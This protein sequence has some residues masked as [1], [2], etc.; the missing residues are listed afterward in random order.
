MTKK[1]Y[2]RALTRATLVLLSLPIVAQSQPPG[3]A[4]A[5]LPAGDAKAFVEGVCTACHQTNLIIGSAGY[6]QAHWRSL[7]DT[8]IKL[9]EV[10]A[11]SVTQYLATNFPATTSRQPELVPGDTRIRFQ[12]WIVPTLGQRPRDPLQMEDGTIWWTGQY[13]SLIGRLNPATGEMKEF[14]LAPDA[15]PHSIIADAEGNIWY[16][17][18]GNGTVGM[19]EPTSGKI[20]VYPMPD[21]AARDP[22]TPIFDEDGRLWFTLQLSSMIGR[23]DTSTGNI[24]LITTP[25]PGARPYGIK[26][27]SEGIIWVAYNGSNKIARV[28]PDS[29]DV[30]EFSTPTPE[31][32]IRR[33]ALTSDDVIWYVDSA[34]GYLGRLDPETGEIT[35][36]PSPSGSL[37]HPYAIEIIDDIVW[38]NESGKRPDALVRFDPSTEQFQSWPIPSGVGIIRHMRKTPDGNLVIH[39][40][41][42]NRI[43]LVT[44]EDDS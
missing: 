4:Q 35:T 16:M 13:G 23:L 15:R 38:Y 31:S 28:D 19:L 11:A 10:Q 9:P 17:G 42:T 41:S 5:A 24:D 43:G 29:M 34:R 25:T 21:P 8:M 44:I 1:K 32:R 3:R 18:N 14:P 20:T 22:H 12:E 2:C 36:W 30:R 26:M 37:S 6:D 40:S 27:N 33:L 39:Q 7:I